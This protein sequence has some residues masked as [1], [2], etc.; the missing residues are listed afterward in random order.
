MLPVINLWGNYVSTW[1]IC[2]C[3]GVVFVSLGATGLYRYL[4]SEW[5]IMPDLGIWLLLGFLFGARI[6]HVL[7]SGDDLRMALNPVKSGYLSTG[8]VV[9]GI[10]VLALY[11]RIRKISLGRMLDSLSPFAALAES[12]GHIGCFLAGCC[13]GKVS[14]LPIAIHFPFDSRAYHGQITQGL[15]TQG[16]PESL[17]VHPVQIY[18][19]VLSFALFFLLLRILFTRKQVGLTA[20]TFLF[21]HGLQR[22]LVQFLRGDNTAMLGDT[23]LRIPQL[24]AAVICLI[25]GLGLWYLLRNRRNCRQNGGS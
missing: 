20:L 12:I 7:M 4:F 2:V 6:G 21:F 13:Y 23:G 5:K 8:G 1:L 10:I 16:A 25:S 9:G 19:A 11:S 22:F 17:A 18:N 15:L 14:S 24:S 3:L